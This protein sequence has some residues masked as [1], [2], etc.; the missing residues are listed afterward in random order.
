MLTTKTAGNLV[1]GS[2]ASQKGTMKIKA[3]RGFVLEGES[4]KPG[5]VVDVDDVVGRRLV[6]SNKAEVVTEAEKPKKGKK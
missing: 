1:P 6:G 5:D 4:I 3:M 2:G